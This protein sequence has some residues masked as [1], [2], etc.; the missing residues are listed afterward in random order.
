[1]LTGK[2][3][4]ERKGETYRVHTYSKIVPSTNQA[5]KGIRLAGVSPTAASFRSTPKKVVPLEST[6]SPD[7]TKEKNN[8]CNTAA[9]HNQERC[10]QE[11]RGPTLSMHFL[12]H[13]SQTTYENR[14]YPKPGGYCF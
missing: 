11:A 8:L 7:P 5:V 2:L 1:M 6:L 14:H 3:Q 10:A 9:C 13:L 4:L 12:I